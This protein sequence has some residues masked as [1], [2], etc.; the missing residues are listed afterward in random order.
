MRGGDPQL[1]TRRMIV[2]HSVYMVRNSRG[3]CI[4]L[5]RCC[6]W[7]WPHQKTNQF[8]G[9]CH[10]YAT[11]SASKAV[12][13]RMHLTLHTTRPTP[14]GVSRLVQTMCAWSMKSRRAPS[15]QCRDARVYVHTT[16][17]MHDVSNPPRP[18]PPGQDVIAFGFRSKVALK[19]GLQLGLL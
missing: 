15:R 11:K 8:I 6:L 1:R 2:S 17:A 5:T 3:S 10:Q 13:S 14:H 12:L 19:E 9:R 16:T 18:R 4:V 7:K